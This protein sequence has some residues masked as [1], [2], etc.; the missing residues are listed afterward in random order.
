MKGHLLYN[1][2]NSDKKNW[3]Q[4][5]NSSCISLYCQP[6]GRKEFQVVFV[7]NVFVLLSGVDFNLSSLPW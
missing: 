5:Q 6:K 7:T 4:N 1:I 3:K 2:H